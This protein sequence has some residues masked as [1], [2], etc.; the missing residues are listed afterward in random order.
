[1]TSLSRFHAVIASL[2]LAL[3]TVFHLGEQW[4]A[5]GGSEAW[6]ER[7]HATSRGPLAI[8]LEVVVIVLPV[9]AWGTLT[10][11][12]AVLRQPIPGAAREGDRGAV[13]VVGRLAPIAAV[14][15]LFFLSVHVGH[16]W[17]PKLLRGASESEQWLALTHELGRP[18]LLVL[19]GIGLT[20]V[21]LHLAASI[22]AGLEA[23]GWIP[24]PDARRAAM[25]VSSVL[26]LSVWILGVQL[27]GWLG[28]GTGTFW[29][30]DV[31]EAPPE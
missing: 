31:V 17:L 11:R 20:A 28:T 3:W 22:P 6:A 5:F 12:A 15:A 1:M 24:T 26:A 21:A 13:R 23:L 18:A 27:V 29:A 30:I 4:A 8:A 10:L 25:L 2:P 19:Y 9:L 14:V 16:L 7:M